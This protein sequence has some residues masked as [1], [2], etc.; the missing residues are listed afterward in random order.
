[1]LGPRRRGA[2][3]PGAVKGT[4]MTIGTSRVALVL[5][6]A[7]FLLGIDECGGEPSDIGPQEPLLEVDPEAIDFGAVEVDGSVSVVLQLHNRGDADLTL[8]DLEIA[9]DPGFELQF[10]PLAMVVAPGTRHDV[11]V[12]FA[13]EETGVHDATIT[14]LSD[15]P[16]RPAVDVAV[17][18]AGVVGDGGG[19]PQ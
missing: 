11:H 18:G 19:A 14:V 9:G 3:H 1:M 10:D 17:T 7:A 12:T 6:L 8:E 5:L 16:D 2:G 4:T 13:P 15:D